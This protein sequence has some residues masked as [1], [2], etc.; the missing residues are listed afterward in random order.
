MSV[1]Y[2]SQSQHSAFPRIAERIFWYFFAEEY[3]WSLLKA[4]QK[5]LPA[6]GNNLINYYLKRSC[7]ALESFMITHQLG[8]TRNSRC[9]KISKTISN[10]SHCYNHCDQ[11]KIAKCL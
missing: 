7:L 5:S 3:S 2:F 10:F 4:Y 1:T 8:Q 11:K 9:T 6:F